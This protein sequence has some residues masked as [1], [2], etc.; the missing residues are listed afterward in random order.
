MCTNWY[1]IFAV[2]G[3]FALIK[4]HRRWHGG[5]CRHSCYAR[6]ERE[7]PCPP[8]IGPGW[9]PPFGGRQRPPEG[10]FL[11][12]RVA[13]WVV[14]DLH[15][16][17]EQ[18][19]V[20]REVLKEMKEGAQSVR[21][22]ASSLRTDLSAALRTE[23]FDEVGAGE[24][25]GKLDDSLESARKKMIDLLARLHQVLDPSQRARLADYLEGR[26]GHG[27]HRWR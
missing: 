19:R 7:D 24:L 22:A 10:G 16:T 21:S 26:F 2:F 9:G 13:D 6:E 18:E 4:R 5:W 1:A 20:V 23:G 12:G 3:L 8:W 25:L 15:L 27:R 14:E 17:G 11:S